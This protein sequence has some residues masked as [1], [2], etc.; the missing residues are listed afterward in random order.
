MAW[1]VVLSMLQEGCSMLLRCTAVSAVA[2]LARSSYNRCCLRPPSSRSAHT[3]LPVSTCSS[4]SHF[5]GSTYRVL[6]ALTSTAGHA[7][8]SKL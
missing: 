7:A 4:L 3:R 6:S 1:Q 2:G 5:A 8:D